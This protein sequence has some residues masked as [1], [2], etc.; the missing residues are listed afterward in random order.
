MKRQIVIAVAL[1]LVIAAPAGAADWLF[2]WKADTARNMISTSDSCEREDVDSAAPD[3]DTYTVMNCDDSQ[4]EGFIIPFW[5]PNGIGA[6]D[7]VDLTM[8]VKAATTGDGCVEASIGCKTIGNSNGYGTVR[9]TSH[10]FTGTTYWEAVTVL[11]VGF[12][13]NTFNNC[14]VKVRRVIDAGA[15]CADDITGDLSFRDGEAE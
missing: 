1:A 11:N 3:D 12:P 7:S 14:V 2:A 5:R 6:L 13:D 10:T 9:R 4:N 8:Y 15:S